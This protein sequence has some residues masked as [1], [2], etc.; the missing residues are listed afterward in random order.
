MVDMR[1]QLDTEK[2]AII[3]AFSLSLIES[4][5]CTSLLK[6]NSTWYSIFPNFDEIITTQVTRSDEIIKGEKY[7][8]IFGNFG[9]GRKYS[10]IYFEDET[11]RFPDNWIE[12]FQTLSHLDEAGFGFFILEPLGFSRNNGQI[13]EKLLNENGY[14]I[15]AYFNTPNE[16][17]TPETTLTPIIVSITRQKKDG[18]FVA[19][20]EDESQAK[21]IVESFL[22]K[23]QGN[24][25]LEG[26]FIHETNFEGFKKLRIDEQFTR[27]KKQYESYSKEILGKLSESI[28]P[29]RK[30]V[31]FTDLENCIYIPK[32]GNSPVVSS[33]SEFQIK[34]QNYYQVKLNESIKNGYLI[35][36]F[37]TK[38]GRMALDS[39][40]TFGTIPH[41]N[42]SGLEDL[43]VF[44]PKKHEQQA[45]IH[46]EKMLRKLRVAIREFEEE[47][48]L[49]PVSAVSIQEQLFPMMDAI[50][51]L[52]DIDRVLDL[53]RQGETKKVEFKE[54][55]GLDFKTQR[56]EKYIE[57]SSL[58]NVVAFL[59]TDGGILLLGVR[60]NG[61]ISGIN[62]ELEKFHKNSVD[63]FK[64]YL[65]DIIK[66]R[67][68]EETFYYIDY[69][70]IS[71]SQKLVCLIDCKPSKEEFFLGDDFYIRTN[72]AAEKLVGEAFARYIKA[73]FR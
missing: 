71:I 72:P 50:G 15:A 56:K 45:I 48:S 40:T 28:I 24:N 9:L 10:D 21:R 52:T 17:L 39:V 29:G 65:K 27:L 2:T 46:T 12:I 7:S 6:I 69:K 43:P 3:Q 59:N 70:I 34:Q 63:K 30:D 57:T 36:F 22:R 51:K 20:L 60:D 5:D 67:I 54:T 33:P 47:L 68:G 25:L 8:L 44:F 55:L 14:F 11:Y 19:E 16:I 13:F 41:K 37:K 49:N 26:Y 58:K 31:K 42:K 35:A 38:I 53:I 1:K 23:K 62:A 32:V 73:R 61:E 64:L 66:S 4:L 18:L